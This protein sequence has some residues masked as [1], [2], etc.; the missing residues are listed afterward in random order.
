MRDGATEGDRGMRK[1]NIKWLSV[2]LLVMLLGMAALAGG[3]QA[4]DGGIHNTILVIDTSASAADPEGLRYDAARLVCENLLTGQGALGVV[5]FG[6]TGGCESYGPLSP[7]ADRAALDGTIGDALNAAAN[8]QGATADIAAALKSAYA[9]QKGFDRSATDVL[10]LASEN[11]APSQRAIVQAGKLRD[12]GASIYI[13]TLLSS[14]AD[15][16][17]RQLTDGDKL[18]YATAGELGSK[19]VQTLVTAESAPEET[20]LIARFPTRASPTPQ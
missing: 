3:A 6:G 15:E 13:V 11:V 5:L 12:E 16:F 10:L 18:V 19:F 14:D 17:L 1:S 20:G 7:D 9:M 2:L 4:E 8:H